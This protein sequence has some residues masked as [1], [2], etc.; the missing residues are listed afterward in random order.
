MERV[1]Q[2]KISLEEIKLATNNFGEQNRIGTGG[3]GKVYRGNLTISGELCLVAVKK[4][5]RT[6][7]DFSGQGNREFSNEIQLLSC[8]RHNNLVSLLGFCNEGGEN[9]LVYEY[10]RHGSLDRHLKD[11]KL[12]WMQRLQISLGMA[13]GLDYLH[14]HVGSNHRVVHRDFKS[15]NVL[16]NEN[17]KAKI[18]DFGFS[19]ITLSN[20]AVTSVFTRVC[21]TVGYID[22]EYVRTN[23]LTKETDV[24]AFGVVLFEI[25]CGRLAYIKQYE[26]HHRFLGSLAQQYYEEE[27][28]S[29]IIY[30]GLIHQINIDSLKV[31]SKVAYQCL[32]KNLK[33]RPTM[34]WII[35][36]LKMALEHQAACSN[37]AGCIRV[38]K[39]GKQS[40]G[41]PWSFELE[42]NHNLKKITIDHGDVIYSLTFTGES[43]G[44][45]SSSNKFGGL[46]GGDTISEVVFDG[47]EEI[48]GINGTIGTRDGC[49]I[50][51]SLSFKTNKRTLGPF[52]RPTESVFSIPW[53]E[54]SL[55]GLYGLAGN[56]IDGIGVYF[57]PSQDILRVGTWGSQTVGT[58]NPWS[59]RLERKHHLKKITIEHGHLIRSLMFTTEHKDSLNKSE[60]AGCHL[61]GDNVSEVT[62][63]WDED[64]K[65]VKGTV[66]L[67]RG[68]N[69]GY[70]AISSLSFVTNKKAHGPFGRA[71]G[72]PFIVPLEDSSFAGF[73]GLAASNH[74]GS[75]G[76]YLKASM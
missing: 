70:V 12:S 25:L 55:V 67:S 66:G 58:Q 60:K 46:A 62:F 64:I 9:I 52:G 4:L 33:E 20:V 37:G 18:A 10:E 73:Y 45:L 38:G 6:S 47:D 35:E 54:G 51:S 1:E 74:I 48:T 15:A 23:I 76:V 29:D 16:L 53:K 49:S 61:G 36:N 19:K 7:S 27:K 21:G 65:A 63:D 2:L 44:V 11:T 50:I 13:H 42:E 59:F 8:C 68:N 75:I 5:E 41:D 72:T 31:F 34:A 30:P 17:W 57:K 22:P 14:N 56:Y 43:R 28:L 71:R 24:Y 3:F 40:G 32:K 26:E 39:W 69:A